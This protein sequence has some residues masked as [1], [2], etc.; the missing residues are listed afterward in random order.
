MRTIK[1][2]ASAYPKEHQIE[3][4]TWSGR[5]D[6]SGKLWFDLHL[7]TQD[8]YRSEGEEYSEEEEEEL[9]D[10]TPYTSLVEWQSK[11][12]WDNYHQ[13]ILS[14]VYWSDEKGILL[15]DKGESFRFDALHNKVFSLDALPLSDDKIESDLAFGIYLLGHDLCA[16][17][18]L[19]FT[20]LDQGTWDIKWEGN[21]ALAYGGFYEYIH[22]FQAHITDAVFEGFYFPT[23]WSIEEAT[24]RFKAVLADFE[25]Y[26]FLDRNPKSN[27][28]EYKL[29]LLK[30]S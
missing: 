5:L 24:T 12:V 10:D 20:P 6:E 15:C 4:F 17:H 7:K 28:R 30:N 2:I 11:S 26:E 8:Y 9:E 29:M 23:S 25:N 13:C 16:N 14:S 18:R 22:E 1:F 27:K 21:I 3:A 19:V